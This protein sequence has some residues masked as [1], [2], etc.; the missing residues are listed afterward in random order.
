[1]ITRLLAFLFVFSIFESIGQHISGCID[2]R[3]NNFN[4][5]ATTNDGSCTYNLTVYNPPLRYLLPP[6]VEETSGLA[7]YNSRFW[8]IND[9]GGL[10]VLYGL[11]TTTGEIIQRI[12]IKNA[13]NR[14]WESL[15]QDNRFMYIGDFGNN[16]GTRDDLTIY[17]IALAAFPLDGDTALTAAIITFKYEDYQG[18]VAKKKENNFDCEALIAVDDS[19]Y[20]LS[21]NWENERT[22]LYR[23]PKEPG[24]Y[25]AKR[26]TSFDSKGLITGA[27]IDPLT[28][29]IILT[30][31]TNKT[32]I[33]FMWILSDYPGHRFFSGNKRRIDMVNLPA[34]QVEAIAYTHPNQGV[35][36]SEGHVLFSQTAFSI[37]TQNWSVSSPS[38]IPVYPAN[39][40]DFNINPNP[41]KGKKVFVEF[42]SDTDG[43]FSFDLYDADGR[44]LKKPGQYF[45]GKQNDRSR[46]KIKINHLTPGVY[47]IRMT[48]GQQHVEKKLIVQ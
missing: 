40:L 15:A 39:D 38:T 9:S 17:K 34:T 35:I 28:G 13:I 22:N 36:T 16:S 30:G 19:L 32:W 27:D 46:I 42:N 26:L 31:Y 43:E 2:V 41:V 10:P 45:S 24:D 33:P 4:S 3:A 8:T 14:D 1:M 5:K 44:L 48:S 12:T 11:D 21:K 29:E 23:L 37:S 20:L 6:E 18:P 25:L 7:Y 47:F